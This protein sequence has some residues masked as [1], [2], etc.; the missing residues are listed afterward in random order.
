[1]TKQTMNKLKTT[2]RVMERQMLGISLRLKIKDIV[3]AVTE[4]KLNFAGRV[5]RFKY[6]R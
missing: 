3:E 4:Q 2:Q 6:D 5:A 1:M